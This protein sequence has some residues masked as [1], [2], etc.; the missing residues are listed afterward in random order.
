M[1]INIP[2][3]VYISYCNSLVRVCENYKLLKII[4]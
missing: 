1:N 3:I 2:V 4:Y